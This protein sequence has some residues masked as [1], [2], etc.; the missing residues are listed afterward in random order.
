[1]PVDRD[2]QPGRLIVIDG[3]DGSGKHTQTLRL[4]DRLQAKAIHAETLAFPQYGQSFFGELAA[5]YLRG[6]FGASGEVD[7]H[8]AAMVFALDRWEARGRLNAWLAEGKVVVLDRYV[9]ANAG[10]QSIKV[11]DPAARAAFTAWVERMEH[12]VLGLPRPDLVI[13]LHMPWQMAQQL[14]DRKADREYL[15]GA[16]RDIHEAD[17]EHLRLAEGAFLDM[18][19]RRPDWR[20]IRCAEGGKVLSPEA[21]SEAVWQKVASL[22]GLD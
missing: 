16:R 7:P 17:D 9:S 15:K 6:E 22:L 21:I 12:E 20:C 3:T 2:R 1:M 18:A 10:H 14:V 11:A 13:L 4:M 5:R 8:L 19:A